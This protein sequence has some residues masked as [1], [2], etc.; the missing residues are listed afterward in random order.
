MFYK[1]SSGNRYKFGKPY[2]YEGYYYGTAL[3]TEEKFL[4]LGFIEVIPETRPNDKYY[5]VTGPDING[6]YEAIPRDV[7]ELKSNQIAQDKES[8]KRILSDTDWYVVRATE[9]GVATAAVPSNVTNFR[10]SVREVCNTR[11]NMINA[12]T[13]LEEF[14]TLM[15]TSKEIYSKELDINIPN[16]N[17]FLPEWPD[18]ENEESN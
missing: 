11:A 10:S 6:H 4:E 3:A 18:I 5:H 12:T 2:T 7:N 17:P 8:A 13:T 15:D 16:P 9:I 1:D 14:A